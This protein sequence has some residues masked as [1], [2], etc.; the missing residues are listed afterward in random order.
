MAAV[1]RTIVRDEAKRFAERLDGAVVEAD[2]GEPILDR[3][4]VV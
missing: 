3:K 4:S 2:E 1:Q